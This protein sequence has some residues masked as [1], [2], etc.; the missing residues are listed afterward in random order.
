MPVTGAGCASVFALRGFETF[1]VVSTSSGF[2]SLLERP[3]AL[4]RFDT[5]STANQS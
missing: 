1:E 2:T 4:Q 5:V 3:E